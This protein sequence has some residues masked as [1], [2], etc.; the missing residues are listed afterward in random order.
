MFLSNAKRGRLQ[1]QELSFPAQN[2]FVA[3]DKLVS[4]HSVVRTLRTFTLHIYV[5]MYTILQLNPSPRIIVT[6]TIFI[7]IQ[8]R[9]AKLWIINFSG[10]KV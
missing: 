6:V 1:R 4:L 2:S 7:Y 10:Q 8:C 3:S 5:Y 9:Q